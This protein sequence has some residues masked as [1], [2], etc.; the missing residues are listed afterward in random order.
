MQTGHRGILKGGTQG[1]ILDRIAREGHLREDH[2]VGAT[3]LGE[4][5]LVSYE[6]RVTGEIT[7]HGVHLGEREANQGHVWSVLPR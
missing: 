5:G 2:E 3:R 6:R 4:A 7:H 1:E